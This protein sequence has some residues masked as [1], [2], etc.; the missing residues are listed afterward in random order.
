MWIAEND[1]SNSTNSTVG[2]DIRGGVLISVCLLLAS[3]LQAVF[4]HQL[5][6]LTMRTGWNLRISMT[7][8]VHDKLLRLSSASLSSTSGKQAINLVSTDVFRFDQFA[9]FMW[10]YLTGPMDFLI[11]LYLLSLRVSFAPA[12]I[13]SLVLILQVTF[14][15]KFGKIIGRLR[16]N[17]AKKTDERLQS[18]KECVGGIETV[19][20]YSWE[21]G[22]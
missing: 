4:H 3:F 11:I 8:M 18:L 21:G 14:Q 10:Y 12:L 19:K 13:G 22:E 1:S 7:A 5:Y 15:L 2:A 20:C 6:Y 16:R 9:P 17:T